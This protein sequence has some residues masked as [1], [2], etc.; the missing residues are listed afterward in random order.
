[1]ANYFIN[2]IVFYGEDKRSLTDLLEKIAVCIDEPDKN[3]VRVFL[4]LA[5]INEK[6]ISDYADGHDHFTY[7]DFEVQQNPCGAYFEVQTESAWSAN[8]EGFHKVLQKNYGG[9][10]NMVYQSEETGC[11]I[12]INSDIEGL[13]FTD[14]YRLDYCRGDESVREY[15][16]SWREAAAFLNEAFPKAKITPYTT[17]A[18]AI[19]RI[20]NLYSF[21]GRKQ[22]YIYFDRFKFSETVGGFAA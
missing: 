21:E 9:K 1:M 7:L 12:F 6:E 4:K 17:S 5:G 16:A 22:E 10:I 14:K 2:R 11:G 18:D 15:F 20:E 8:M 19:N 13:F 3:N